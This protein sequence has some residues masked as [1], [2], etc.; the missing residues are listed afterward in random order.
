MSDNETKAPDKIWMQID[1]AGESLSLATWAQDK[2]NDSDVEYV[3]ADLAQ[4]PLPV[5]EEE[6]VA[7][8][9]ERRAVISP[10]P[11][12]H[13]YPEH[14]EARSG[15]IRFPH[16][17]TQVVGSV[18]VDG[19]SAVGLRYQVEGHGK[20]NGEDRWSVAI[21]TPPRSRNTSDWDGI[22]K[23]ASRLA[24]DQVKA[25]GEFIANAPTDIDFLLSLLDHLRGQWLPIESAPNATVNNPIIVAEIRDYGAV[26]CAIVHKTKGGLFTLVGGDQCNRWATHWMPLP[27][28]PQSVVNAD[29]CQQVTKYCELHRKVPYKPQPVIDEREPREE[30]CTWTLDSAAD[31][32]N[33][34]CNNSWQFETG[35]L[36]GNHMYFCCY[37]GKVLVVVVPSDEQAPSVKLFQ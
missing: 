35:G 22:G 10:S 24:H 37:C 1:D 8:I 3:R 27:A 20:V 13:F 5:D 12:T 15:V 33:S 19:G 14:R 25:D 36:K 6:R 21:I 4:R 17:D 7:E 9:R 30:Q 18:T 32:W 2:I 34:A 23:E 31:K 16:V 29:E 11:W 26:R 28:P